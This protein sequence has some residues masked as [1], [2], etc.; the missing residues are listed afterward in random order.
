MPRVSG[1][2]AEQQVIAQAAL[3]PKLIA[4][5]AAEWRADRPGDA[6]CIAELKA[7]HGF[8]E[9]AAARFLQVFDTAVQSVAGRFTG[10]GPDNNQESAVDM[11]PN[12]GQTA[13][14]T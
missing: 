10:V 13:G 5:Y 14:Q 9:A 4:H 6:V 7:V 11:P 12:N 3:K 8:T 1:G 2:L